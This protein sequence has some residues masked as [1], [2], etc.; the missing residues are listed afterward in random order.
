MSRHVGRYVLSFVRAAVRLVCIQ[1]P[2]LDHGFTC[3]FFFF[4]FH[5]LFLKQ[6]MPCTILLS[7]RRW[8]RYRCVIIFIFFK[9]IHCVN[10]KQCFF[11]FSKLLQF[12]GVVHYFLCFSIHWFLIRRYVQHV[13]ASE[14]GAMTARI[15]AEFAHRVAVRDNL[16]IVHVVVTN[17]KIIS[18]LLFL[19]FCQSIRS[20]RRH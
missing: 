18:M 13:R 8:W 12:V 14:R 4:C 17:V 10:L 3:L 16:L 6:L 1:Y 11:I 2:I 5:S 19:L 7:L 9:K 20:W 15:K